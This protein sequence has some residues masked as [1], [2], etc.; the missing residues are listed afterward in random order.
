MRVSGFG[1]VLLGETCLCRVRPRLSEDG[2]LSQPGDLRP[3]ASDN[4]IDSDIHGASIF[5]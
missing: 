2:T 5:D 1:V 4:V 3:V